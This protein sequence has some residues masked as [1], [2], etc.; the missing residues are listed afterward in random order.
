MLIIS[1][2]IADYDCKCY[3]A[4]KIYKIGFHLQ[5]IISIPLGDIIINSLNS[6]ITI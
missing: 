1:L 5:L 3:I 2:C 4:F 6:N